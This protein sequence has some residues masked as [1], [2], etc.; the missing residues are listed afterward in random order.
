MYYFAYGSNM[1]IKQMSIRCP[2]AMP[3]GSAVLLDYALVERRYA[4]IEKRDGAQV[5]GLLWEISDKNLRSLDCYEGYPSLYT[6]HNV[7]LN[8]KDDVVTAITYEM[9]E[10]AKHDLE[11]VY[12]SPGYRKI[13]SDGAV[14]SGVE[15]S[16]KAGD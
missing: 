12:Y 4:D 6:R 3:L 15:D 13:C 1:N 16:F 5:N 11:G 10:D 14:M 2:G 9:T 7:N 8:F